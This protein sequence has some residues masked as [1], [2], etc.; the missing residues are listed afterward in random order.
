M[1]K[2]KILTYF[3]VIAFCLC[4]CVSCGDKPTPIQKDELPKQAQFFVD[5]TFPND[6][7]VIVMKIAKTFT[8]KYKV[9]T[10]QGVDV[11][12]DADGNWIEC[13]GL[14]LPNNLLPQNIR[15]YIETK[16][17]ETKITQIEKNKKGYEIELNNEYELVFDDEG[18]FKKLKD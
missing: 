11:E 12:F 13:E 18:K 3:H 5:V 6:K 7:P 17:P 2:L 14:D 4:V 16:F 1:M 8:T 10:Q 9:K 15:T